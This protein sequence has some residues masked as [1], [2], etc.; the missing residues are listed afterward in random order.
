[1]RSLEK[2]TWQ[3]T[4]ILAG[5]VVTAVR[6]LK[7]TDGPNIA[8]LGSGT[9]AAILGEASLV[10]EYQFVIVPIALGGGRTVFL[11][12]PSGTAAA[13][14]L[15]TDVFRL[16]KASP[17][18]G[19]LVIHSPLVRETAFRDEFADEKVVFEELQPH[20]PGV[21]SGSRHARAETIV[22]RSLRS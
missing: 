10:D 19:R 14:L 6:A 1:M 4:Q 2:A 9:I 21:P 3:N 22:L 5:D 20:E 13:N 15:R 12:V 7:A 18:I 11:C 8:V 17:L 16:L